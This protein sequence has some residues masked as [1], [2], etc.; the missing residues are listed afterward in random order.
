MIKNFLTILF[1]IPVLAYAQ[2]DSLVHLYA[3]GGLTNDIGEEVQP[4]PDGGYIVVGSTASSGDGNTDVYLLKVDSLC[5]YEWSKALGES[6]NDWGYSVKP[7]LD[8]GYIVA[9]TTNS[10]GNSYQACLMKRDSLGNYVWKKT[11]GGSDWDMAYD[12]TQTYDSGFVFCGET[13]N[14]TNGYSDVFIVRTNNIGDTLWTKTIGGNLVDKGN[15]IIETL[16][17]NIV[18]AGIK[19][20]ITDSTQAYVLKF[21]RNGTLLWDSIYGGSEYEGIN[22]V[23]E[24][25]PNRYTIAGSTNSNVTG[26]LDHYLLNLDQNGAVQWDFPMDNA[27]EDDE[28]FGM[29]VLPNNQILFI[30][31][32]LTGGGGKKNVTMFTLSPGMFDAF[33]GGS[34]TV[35]SNV[36]DDIIKSVTIN[37]SGRI[38]GAGVTN[39]FGNGNKDVLLLRMDIIL[40]SNDTTSL[41]YND[42]APIGIEDVENNTDISIFPTITDDHFLIKALKPNLFVKVEII[43]VKGHV[44]NEYYGVKN[45]VP[46][47]HLS[48][49]I[50]FVTLKEG[51]ETVFQTKFIRN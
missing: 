30:G 24:N 14:N 28:I 41:V 49:G 6:N 31:Y 2:T 36:E 17:S 11:Y 40:P 32:T 15:A 33:W 19:N 1:L 27:A 26:D 7:T 12:V 44:V 8:N 48:S 16:D 47:S 22:D 10:Y 18:V 20:T 21:N 39:S 35:I 42:I 13:Y 38:V 23:I 29:D 37:N 34:S 5:N 51:G 50:Y 43:N 9:L 3:F 45:R 25:V 46:V 4:T